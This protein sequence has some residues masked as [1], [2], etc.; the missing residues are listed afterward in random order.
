VGEGKKE[1]DGRGS[2][3]VEDEKEEKRRVKGEEGS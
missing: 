1:V 3:E 2:D